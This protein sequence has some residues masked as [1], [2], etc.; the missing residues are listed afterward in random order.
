MAFAIGQWAVLPTN[1]F[2]LREKVRLRGDVD[3][4]GSYRQPRHHPKSLGYDDS[5]REVNEDLS[6]GESPNSFSLR[7]KVRLRGDVDV[8]GSYRQLASPPQ[9]PRLR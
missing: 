5:A 9:I 7:E 3:V 6:I 4:A 8:A 2:S 1:P